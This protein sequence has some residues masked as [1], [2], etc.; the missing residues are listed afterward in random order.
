MLTGLI[1]NGLAILAAGLAIL[2][3]RHR[4]HV[5][6]GASG[7]ILLTAAIVLMLFAGELARS[8]GLGHWAT[9]TLVDFE[10]WIGPS[11]KVI[12]TLIVLAGVILVAISV[13]RT[14]QEKALMIA[15]LLPFAFAMFSSG[16]FHSLDVALQL[17]ATAVA[18]KIAS[19]LGV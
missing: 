13:F 19:G 14:A 1:G 17:P 7:E 9:S 15:F 6:G 4:G 18:A 8:T 10:G 12:I 11:G 16:L 3:R 2:I 5:P